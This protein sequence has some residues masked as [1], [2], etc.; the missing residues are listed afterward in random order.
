MCYFCGQK[1]VADSPSF[2]ECPEKEDAS[3]GQRWNYYHYQK[4]GRH[5]PG[6]EYENKRDCK[7]YQTEYDKEM[8]HD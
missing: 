1:C 4:Y 8:W 2:R 7:C 3:D 6:A 5:C